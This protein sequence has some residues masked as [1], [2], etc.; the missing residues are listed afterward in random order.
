MDRKTSQ[1]IS[2]ASFFLG[3]ASLAGWLLYFADIFFN[4]SP[5]GEWQGTFV[6][7]VL[8]GG[9]LSLAT[10][11][12]VALV[13]R[14]RNLHGLTAL[15]SLVIAAVHAVFIWSVLSTLEF[16][17][18]DGVYGGFQT[19]LALLSALSAV[20]SFQG[21]KGVG[22]FEKSPA[23]QTSAETEP[24]QVKDR[25]QNTPNG[26][27]YWLAVVSFILSFFGVTAIL[28]LVLGFVAL[29]EIRNSAGAKT[30]AGLAIAAIVLGFLFVLALIA[31]AAS[32]LVFAGM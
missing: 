4:S 14:A 26:D 22:V 9:V 19:I 28:G 15:A 3:V 20:F 2:R 25:S 12:A 16:I 21:M 23:D 27:L 7:Y 8:I 31:W 5:I 32:I 24:N 10:L 18:V 1:G 13:P 6:A 11:V 17:L 29:R 30:G